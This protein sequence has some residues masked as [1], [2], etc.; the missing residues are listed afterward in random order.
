[1]DASFFGLTSN[2]SIRARLGA[3]TVELSDDHISSLSLEDELKLDLLLWFPSYIGAIADES[4]DSALIIQQLALKSYAK[5][6]CAL[7]VIPSVHMGF[8]QK[9]VN[10]DDQGV[11]F[12]HENSINHLK[13]DLEE[14]LAEARVKVLGQTT[15]YTPTVVVSTTKTLG[16]GISKPSTDVIVG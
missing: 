16:I 10:K 9:K 6:F 3:S 4:T 13:N 12:Q 5:T 8:L 14:Q 1:M 15:D 11:R 7:Q 2:N